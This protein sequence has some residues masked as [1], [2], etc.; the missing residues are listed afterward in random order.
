MKPRLGTNLV[1]LHQ[2]KASLNYEEIKRMNLIPYVDDVT[3]TI[4]HFFLMAVHDLFIILLKLQN[5]YIYMC[6]LVFKI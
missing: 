6:C 5:E 3:A 4:W 1:L 2:L